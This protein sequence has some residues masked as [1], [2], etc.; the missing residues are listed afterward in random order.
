MSIR[1][2]RYAAISLTE[3]RPEKRALSHARKRALFQALKGQGIIQTK[4]ETMRVSLDGTIG[5]IKWNGTKRPGRPPS[6]R[7]RVLFEGNHQEFMAYLA[8]NRALFEPV[9]IVDGIVKVSAVEPV[10]TWK[11]V[12]SLVIGAAAAV[13]AGYLGG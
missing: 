9:D 13:A 4:L 6:A 10:G 11:L 12:A 2:R 8:K 3:D 5:I 1:E 7:Q